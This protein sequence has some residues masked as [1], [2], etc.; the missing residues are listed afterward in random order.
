MGLFRESETIAISKT[1][2]AKNPFLPPWGDISTPEG[3]IESLTRVIL[4]QKGVMAASHRTAPL[5]PS[6]SLPRKEVLTVDRT[7]SGQSAVSVL[8]ASLH[9]HLFA[10]IL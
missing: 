9:C 2:F 5:A 1:S 10:E 4:R 6:L 3:I 8:H 7:P